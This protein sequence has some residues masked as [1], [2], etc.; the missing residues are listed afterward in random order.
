[1]RSIPEKALRATQLR[2]TLQYPLYKRQRLAYSPGRSAHA[3]PQT[4]PVDIRQLSN[5]MGRRHVPSMPPVPLVLNR[6]FVFD[7]RSYLTLSCL[8]C[9]SRIT[10]Q[11]GRVYEIRGTCTDCG[12]LFDFKISEERILRGGLVRRCRRHGRA[13]HGSAVA[14]QDG[15]LAQR[16]RQH[17]WV[18]R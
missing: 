7:G 17:V 8:E 3:D 2:E 12:R 5:A 14:K 13:S 15:I 10:G 1:M 6:S 11:P 9:A 16:K 18:R 4:R